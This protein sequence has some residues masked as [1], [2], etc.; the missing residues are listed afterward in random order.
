VLIAHKHRGLSYEEVAVEL[1]LSVHT[2]E[3]YVT[4]AKALIRTMTWER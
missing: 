3:K 1:G 4:Q 2:V